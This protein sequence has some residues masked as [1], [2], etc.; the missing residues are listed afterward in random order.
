MAS[1]TRR[2]AE[3]HRERRTARHVDVE[4]EP[5]LGGHQRI[6]AR[7]EA[8]LLV[9]APLRAREPK[10]PHVEDGIVEVSSRARHAQRAPADLRGEL[11]VER[12]GLARADAAAR[13]FYAEP[14]DVR[15]RLTE[16]DRTPR[17]PASTGGHEQQQERRHDQTTT[18]HP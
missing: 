6:V 1:R 7:E 16:I 9:D 17:H 8:T 4:D 18:A 2:R 10:L 5:G 12:H 14:H 11:D 3:T 15:L 13:R